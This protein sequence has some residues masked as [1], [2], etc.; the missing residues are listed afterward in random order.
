M[1]TLALPVQTCVGK[2]TEV[3]AEDDDCDSNGLT[4]EDLEE[5][6]D[7]WTPKKKSG[8]KTRVA[9]TDRIRT[10]MT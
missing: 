3:F 1:S 6:S 4:F 2:Y 5:D 10:L 8:E 9:S 7:D